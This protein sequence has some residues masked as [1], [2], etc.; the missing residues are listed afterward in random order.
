MIVLS[1]AD[2]YLRVLCV[3]KLWCRMHSCD[4]KWAWLPKFLDTLMC[5]ISRTPLFSI[6]RSATVLHSH[7]LVFINYMRLN[8]DFAQKKQEI[9]G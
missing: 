1:Q 5:A 7:L 9:L 2:K 8:V 4:Q 3:V 6:S